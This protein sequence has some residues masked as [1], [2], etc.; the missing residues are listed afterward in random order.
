MRIEYFSG[1][2]KVEDINGP[3]VPWYW[4]CEQFGHPEPSGR[5]FYMNENYYFK[6]EKDATMF[7]LRWA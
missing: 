4:A 2:H 7:L 6:E 5:W 1:W 3:V